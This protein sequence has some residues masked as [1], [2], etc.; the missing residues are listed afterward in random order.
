MKC[1]MK[2]QELCREKWDS[3]YGSCFSTFSTSLPSDW[4]VWAHSAEKKKVGRGV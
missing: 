1:L 2:D 3:A 4:H